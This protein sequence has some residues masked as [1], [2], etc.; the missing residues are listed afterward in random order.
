MSGLEWLEAASYIVTIIGLPL[1]IGVYINDRRRERQTDEE[2]IFLRLADEYAA[3]MRLVIDNADLNLLS[4]V[5][6]G[7]LNEEQRERKRALFA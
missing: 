1:A 4:P 6:K 7:E 2:E 3:F 5:A